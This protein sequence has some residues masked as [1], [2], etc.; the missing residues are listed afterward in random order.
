MLKFLKSG[1]FN[2]RDFNN[3][4]VGA[5][6]M[7]GAA[8]FF[9]V[10]VVTLQNKRYFDEKYV[11]FA[12]FEK[13]QGIALGTVVQ[14]NGVAVGS[15][16]SVGLRSDGSVRMKLVIET[17]YK[18]H[19]T[20]SSRIY[21]VRPKSLISERALNIDHGEDG[22]VLGARE[23]IE[24]GKAQDIETL[25]ADL[26]ALIGHVESIAYSTDTLISMVMN[27]ASTIGS[28]INS[29]DLYDK[30]THQI[31]ALEELTVDA[32]KM[33][34]IVTTRTPKMFNKLDTIADNTH[35]LTQDAQIAMNNLNNIMVK[36]DTMMTDI[37]GLVQVVQ[38]LMIDSED[39]LERVD[40][41]VQG[42]SSY[43]FIRHKLPNK[44]EVLMK[45]EEEW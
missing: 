6:L 20:T 15:V 8:I 40:D 1:Q 25:L 32:N 37:S 36:A 13:G 18:G 14:I 19:I 17:Q 35:G 33:V 21:A 41:L 39:K 12:N 7:T 16:D 10:T 30:L 31:D 11:L 42:I 29:R 28:L 9:I 5:F 43:W 3:L 26:N 24:S 2:P 44:D 45:N 38:E 34:S 23:E 27:P 22:R 4:F